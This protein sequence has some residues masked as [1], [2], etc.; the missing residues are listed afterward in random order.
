MLTTAQKNFALL[1]KRIYLFL[2]ELLDSLG[3]YN[4][5]KSV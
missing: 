4:G 5:R 1:G 2:Q 3:G